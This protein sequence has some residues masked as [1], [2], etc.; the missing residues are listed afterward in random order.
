MK[1]IETYQTVHGA[2]EMD[3][4]NCPACP[5]YS[6]VHGVKIEEKEERI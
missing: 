2:E 1:K 5:V 4:M 3:E 6:S